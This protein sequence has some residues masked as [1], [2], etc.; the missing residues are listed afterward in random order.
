MIY[1]VND[2][3]ILSCFFIQPPPFVT[4]LV[5]Y[6]WW[7]VFH[8]FRVFTSGKELV[9]MLCKVS[10]MILLFTFMCCTELC[11]GLMVFVHVVQPIFIVK[12]NEIVGGLA[13]GF[14]VV[15]LVFWVVVIVYSV[16][17]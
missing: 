17:G 12:T 8:S 13:Y 10:F 3:N 1:D 6:D 7:C 16:V 2:F 4:I 14:T 11:G 9:F 15:L 5:Q